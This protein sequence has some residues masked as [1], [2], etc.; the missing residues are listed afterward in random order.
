TNTIYAVFKGNKGYNSIFSEPKTF[1]VDKK[2]TTITLNDIPE[3]QYSDLIVISGRVTK[4]TGETIGNAP[5]VLMINGV[6]YNAKT[7][8]S[9]NYAINYTATQVGT[10]NI[11]VTFKGNSVYNLSNV[12]KTFTVVN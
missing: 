9:G 5:I 6:Q 3:T 8:A 4:S 10:N 12:T 1:T 7:D 11:T 2:D